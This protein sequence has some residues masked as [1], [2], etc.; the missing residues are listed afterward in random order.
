MFCYDNYFQVHIYD[1]NW[2]DQVETSKY[3]YQDKCLDVDVYDLVYVI[4]YFILDRNLED[5]ELFLRLAGFSSFTLEEIPY[6]ITIPLDAISFVEK[7]FGEGFVDY[8]YRVKENQICHQNVIL[9]EQIEKNNH[10]LTR[11]RDLKQ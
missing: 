9:R 6:S 7:Y 2:G 3:V 8:F 10:V 5:L 11:I 1:K 4:Y